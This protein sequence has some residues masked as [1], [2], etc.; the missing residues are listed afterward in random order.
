MPDQCFHCFAVKEIWSVTFLFLCPG[1]LLGLCCFLFYFLSQ[2]FIVYS[3]SPSVQKED[4]YSFIFSFIR[5]LT[6][7][8]LCVQL[9]SSKWRELSLYLFFK[10]INMN[11]E[12]HLEYIK[13]GSDDKRT[14]Q[15][16]LMG[17]IYDDPELLFHRDQCH[18]VSQ[19]RPFI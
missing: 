18:H 4:I 5:V 16:L 19:M 15:T 10:S 6:H 1:D 2:L 12:T 11:A 17:R 7:H 14:A 13:R 8:H 9:A 3:I